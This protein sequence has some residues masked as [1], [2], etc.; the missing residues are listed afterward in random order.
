MNNQ[1]SKG[2][3]VQV[4]GDI[5]ARNYELTEFFYVKWLLSNSLCIPSSAKIKSL[6]STGEV[7][8]EWLTDLRKV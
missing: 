1:L 2:D 5:P 3:T 6:D 8:H 7:R 4:N